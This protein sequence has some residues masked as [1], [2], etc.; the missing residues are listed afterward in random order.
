MIVMQAP[1]ELIQT[2]S[3]FPNPMIGDSVAAQDTVNPILTQSGKIFT[4]VKTTNRKH[5]V[6]TFE[7]KREKA[8]ELR[9]FFNAYNSQNIRL[10]LWNGEVWVVTFTPNN[11]DFE[12]LGRDPVSVVQVAFQGEKL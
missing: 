10:T 11:L 9:E 2:T 1:H 7:L 8:I 4:Y 6:L 3:V 12:N 5:L